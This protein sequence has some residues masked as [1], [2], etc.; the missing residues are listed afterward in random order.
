MP[1]QK[2]LKWSQLRVGL[3]VIFASLALAVL[4]FLMS[5]TVG[6]FSPKLALYCYFED[7]SGLRVGAPVR[8]EGVD[9]GNVSALRLVPRSEQ[10]PAEKTTPA[11]DIA[12]IT[13]GGGKAPT[14]AVIDKPVQVKITLGEKYLFDLRKDSIAAL[15]TAGVLGETFVNI[16]S[17]LATGQ[18]VQNGDT[19]LTQPA[20][21]IE[22][23]VSA[24]Q[25]AIQNMDV[26]NRRADRIL[27][28]EA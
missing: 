27:T 13:P 25:S 20:N 8:L 17:T 10:P 28:S 9:I 19:L 3:T 2:Q 22:G 7:A 16:D 4:V 24:S 1:S 23:M 5:G 11:A 15:A 18:T 14:P 12:Q 26:L 6:L 21:N